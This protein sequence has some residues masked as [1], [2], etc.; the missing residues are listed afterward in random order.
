MNTRVYCKSWAPNRTNTTWGIMY[1]GHNNNNNNN[2]RR[3]PEVVRLCHGYRATSSPTFLA[4]LTLTARY[5]SKRPRICCWACIRGWACATAPPRPT[6]FS[7]R[8]SSIRMA[9]SIWPSSDECWRK[10]SF[11]CM[12]LFGVCFWSWFCCFFFSSLFSLAPL[13]LT[14]SGHHFCSAVVADC[15][16][17]RLTILLLYELSYFWFYTFFLSRFYF[18]II[19]NKWALNLIKSLE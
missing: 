5:H 1:K 2:N 11:E 8:S 18:F 9:T 4:W 17:S 16:L 6:T 3:Y 7:S 13:V 10:S 14:S 19:L 15:K 12:V